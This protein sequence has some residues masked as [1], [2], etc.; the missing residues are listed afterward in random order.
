[1]R[2]SASSH[3]LSYRTKE[4]VQS[5]GPECLTV[6]CKSILNLL[7]ALLDEY[8]PE[9]E[10]SAVAGQKRP[11]QLLQTVSRKR[12]NLGTE[13]IG[14]SCPSNGSI[15]AFRH[16]FDLQYSK[17]CPELRPCAHF[18]SDNE[19]EEDGLVSSE[20]ALVVFLRNSC[21][22]STEPITLDCGDVLINYGEHGGTVDAKS[23]HIGEQWANLC[24]IF[25][26]P[27][28]Y[29]EGMETGGGHL[30]SWVDALTR[31]VHQPAVEVA[32][33][34]RVVVSPLTSW[35]DT[36]HT[37]PFRL[38]VEVALS[39]RLPAIF[40]PL[41]N[42]SKG[43]NRIE[44]EKSRRGLLHLAFPPTTF[45]E[46]SSS[47]RGRVDVPFLYAVI[48]PARAVLHESADI[49]L[50]PQALLPKL[51]PFQRRTV[52]WML[53]REGKAFGPSG[54][55]TPVV[56]DP[57]ELPILWQR[58]T[59]QQ[60]D[61]QLTWYYHRL[62]GT[63]TSEPPAP[64]VVLGGILAE[65]PGL[66]KTLESIALILLNPGIGRGLSHVRCDPEKGMTTREIRVYIVLSLISF[67]NLRSV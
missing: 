8:S 34:L 48:Q 42:L 30:F 52:A 9:A 1:M 32:A 22:S 65:E 49:F 56:T 13:Q 66:G 60:G 46:T 3:Q 15:L 40:Q 28:P 43:R 21:T 18:I 20:E 17:E 59:V 29:T 5:G 47:F 67:F 6:N 50:Q 14:A 26:I 19:A 58:V 45:P 41:A 53:S 62:T 61:E 36:L 51:L 37:L 12:R 11:H 7:H 10:L 44:I 54:D 64:W 33:R 55:L 57:E 39:F 4:R 63:L 24:N 38:V 35:D 2:S 25:V 31:F 16:E 23:S 27:P